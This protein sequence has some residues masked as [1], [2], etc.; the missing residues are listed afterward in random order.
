M[1]FQVIVKILLLER[2]GRGFK[3]KSKQ[4][5]PQMEN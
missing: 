4:L 1:D 5:G 3:G 2:L